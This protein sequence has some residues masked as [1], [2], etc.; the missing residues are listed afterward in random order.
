MALQLVVC[1]RVLIQDLGMPSGQ[2]LN[3]GS[4][5]ASSSKRKLK[6]STEMFSIRVGGSPGTKD[7]EEK[8]VEGYFFL[9]LDH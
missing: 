2:S 8:K 1:G 4:G 9:H 7:P 6:I 3:P 5:T